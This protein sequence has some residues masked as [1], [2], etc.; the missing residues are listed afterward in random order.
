MLGFDF[1]GVFFF[2]RW[3]ICFMRVFFICGKLG[4]RVIRILEVFEVIYSME[5]GI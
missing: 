5:I 4:L 1:R 2:V 3:V